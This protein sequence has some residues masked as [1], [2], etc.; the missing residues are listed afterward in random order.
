MKFHVAMKQNEI[1]LYAFTS[2]IIHCI[3]DLNLFPISE[4]HFPHL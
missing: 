4:P 1:D 2:K 3:C